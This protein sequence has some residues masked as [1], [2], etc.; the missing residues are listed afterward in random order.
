M[1]A[2]SVGTARSA[3]PLYYQFHY[4][5]DTELDSGSYRDIIYD[6]DANT[7]LLLNVLIRTL[8]CLAYS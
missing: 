4:D 5:Q 6:T 3:L 7:Y 1:L 2:G 8:F